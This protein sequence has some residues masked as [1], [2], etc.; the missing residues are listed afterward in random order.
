MLKV[1]DRPEYQIYHQMKQRCYNSNHPQYPNYGGRGITICDR[2]LEP[3]GMGFL[4]FL[5]DMGERPA[6]DYSIERID[7]NGNYEPSNCTWITMTEQT[8]NKRTT[9]ILKEG[10]IFGKLTVI[11]EVDFKDRGDNN[12]RRMFLCKCQCGNEVI[13]RMDKLRQGNISS[14]GLKPCN[15]H[16]NHTNK[17]SII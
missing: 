15:K 10:D 17:I 12:K 8:M 1:T 6:G 3:N 13:K 4:N 2:W 14:C 11:K 9:A 7:V 5:Q 16:S